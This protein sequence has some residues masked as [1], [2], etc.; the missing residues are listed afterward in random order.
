MRKLSWLL[1]LDLDGTLWDHLDIS[2]LTP[3]F[4]RVGEDVIEDSMG[5]RVRLF[6]YM[7][8]LAVWARD[9]G[10]GVVSLSWNDREKALAALRAFGV[11]E[12]F[13]WHVIEPHPWKGKALS[14]FL[15]ESGLDIPPE[16]MIYFDDRDIHLD[17]IYS[18]VGRVRYVRSQVDCSS[19]ESCKSLVEKLLGEASISP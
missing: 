16:R 19:L 11:E 18:H 13:D 17:D 14:R 7:V 5:E 10:A 8:N 2:S 9:M 12:V 3:P 15:R 6:R 1:L 4:R